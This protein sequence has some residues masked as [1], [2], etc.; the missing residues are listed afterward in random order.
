MI[1]SNENSSNTNYQPSQRPKRDYSNNRSKDGSDQG[2]FYTRDR[3]NFKRSNQ[4]GYKSR[5]P[6]RTN[7]ITEDYS[8]IN[9]HIT[10]EQVDACGFKQFNFPESLL[11][12]LVRLEFNNPT[13]IQ[14]AV[15]EDALQ[16]LDILASSKTGSGK[17][18][19]FCLPTICKIINDKTTKAIIVTPTREIATQISKVISGICKGLDIYYSLV[20]GGENMDKQFAS[21]SK[22]P[23]I[24]IGTPGRIND[25]IARGSINC[26]DISIVIMD[27]ADRM[28]DMGFEPQIK[29]IL[30]HVP[31]TSQNMM[32]SATIPPEIKR[33][34]L[35][36]LKDPK[37]I[38]NVDYNDMQKDVKD[39]KQDFVNIYGFDA[40]YKAL[41]EDLD[42]QDGSVI[43]FVSTK[44]TVDQMTQTLTEEG[45]S[46]DCIHGDCRQQ[47]R[48]RVIMSFRNKKFKILIATDV[49]ARGLD[50]PHIQ[51]VINFDMP[52]NFDDYVHRMGRTNRQSGMSG[53]ILNFISQK[54]SSVCAEIKKN[55]KISV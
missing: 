42:K 40:K 9:D 45:Y 22:N 35:S 16:G 46:V 21:L 29:N 41:K 53:T 55:F 7:E 28:L 19:G 15:M 20:I 33:L 23:H 47:V 4:D 37:F 43:V 51:R 49:V 27:E 8:T 39:I 24:L 34:S 5:F 2:R 38:T 13:D 14:K 32:F 11:K 18:L 44:Q 54:D 30:Q 17:T 48:S 52:N 10:Q 36:Y 26:K 12:A 25:H 3:S 6:R 50:I 1:T 31:K